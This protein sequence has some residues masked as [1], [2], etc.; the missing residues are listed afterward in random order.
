MT[1]IVL[2]G[3]VPSDA[4][5][6][7]A[8]CVESA[9]ASPSDVPSAGWRERKAAYASARSSVGGSATYARPANPT[10][11]T[12]YLDGIFARN[13]R[14]ALRAAWRRVGFTSCARI[15]NE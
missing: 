14:A 7:R 6:R 15:D 5:W 8:S 4:R 12:R 9:T 2:G 10:I 11:A 3:I 13:A 1:R